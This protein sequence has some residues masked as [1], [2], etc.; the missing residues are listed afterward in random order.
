MKY[1]SPLILIFLFIF[2]LSYNS[3]CQNSKFDKTKNLAA[4][5]YDSEKEAA[6]KK[7]TPDVSDKSLVETI[8]SFGEPSSSITVNSTSAKGRMPFYLANYL[9][10]ADSFVTAKVCRWWSDT[11]YREIS[12][13]SS[14]NLW[15]AI[16]GHISKSSS[17]P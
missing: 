11:L 16:G 8:N 14:D 10:S 17:V 12:Y 15:I 6:L 13:K 7:Y 9:N 3:N 1:T 5:V 2:S 4:A